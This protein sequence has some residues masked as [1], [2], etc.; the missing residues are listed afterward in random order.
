MVIIDI[1]TIFPGQIHQ[2]QNTTE[3]PSAQLGMKDIKG[4]A[5]SLELIPQPFMMH[6]DCV[7][8]KMDIWH[9]YLQCLSMV[10]FED[11]LQKVT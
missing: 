11:F 8:R 1:M 5:T 2:F 4:A 6:K 10:L 3:Y 9:R 7:N